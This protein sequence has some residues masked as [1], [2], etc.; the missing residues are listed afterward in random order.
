MGTGTRRALFI[1][2]SSLHE[3]SNLGQLVIKDERRDV[4]HIN[5][6]LF[7]DRRGL[8]RLTLNVISCKLFW[9][10]GDKAFES[11]CTGKGAEQVH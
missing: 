9:Q 4:T 7:R 1:F 5:D 2:A 10:K 6:A 8:E 3:S 11:L